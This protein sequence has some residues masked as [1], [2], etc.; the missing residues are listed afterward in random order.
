M[1]RQWRWQQLPRVGARLSAWRTVAGTRSTP[2]V[3][4]GR[5]EH[6]G[7]GL[8]DRPRDR[9]R[10]LVPGRRHQPRGPGLGRDRFAASPTRDV[11]SP[12]R[13]PWKRDPDTD[14]HSTSCRRAISRKVSTSTSFG[15]GSLAGAA[16]APGSPK[17]TALVNGLVA[18]G[19]SPT[20]TSTATTAQS[21]VTVPTTTGTSSPVQTPIPFREVRPSRLGPSSRDRPKA[22]HDEGWRPSSDCFD[23]IGPPS[24]DVD[25]VGQITPLIHK[26]GK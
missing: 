21:T 19:S 6:G 5:P 26:R 24:R 13:A 16:P 2:D 8:H 3:S 22:A 17:G 23:G 14:L 11:P 20:N 4:V 18:F 9:P 25:L 15:F 1:V 7:R 12:A 10:L